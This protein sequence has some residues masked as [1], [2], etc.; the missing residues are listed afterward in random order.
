VV[1][2][3]NEDYVEKKNA[4]FIDD[5]QIEEVILTEETRE[6]NLDK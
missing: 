2:P 4:D 3:V 6:N 5:Y 1:N